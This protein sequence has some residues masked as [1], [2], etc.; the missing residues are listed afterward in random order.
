MVLFINVMLFILFIVV[1]ALGTYFLGL[2]IKKLF[3]E[4]P[5]VLEAD[6]GV[7]LIRM[8][9]ICRLLPTSRYVRNDGKVN[10]KVN[11]LNTMYHFKTIVEVTNMM[12]GLEPKPLKTKRRTVKELKTE[13]LIDT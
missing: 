10:D 11:P 5:V 8:Y 3:K 9:I 12:E 13:E 2:G 6:N 7:Y 1:L 4:R